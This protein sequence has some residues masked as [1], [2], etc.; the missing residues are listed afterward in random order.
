[1]QQLKFSICFPQVIPLALV[2]KNKGEERGHQTYTLFGTCSMNQH[3]EAE[4]H[5]LLFAY[6]LYLVA[7]VDDISRGSEEGSQLL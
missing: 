2:E 4:H 5:E 1:V 3:V 7:I 6:L